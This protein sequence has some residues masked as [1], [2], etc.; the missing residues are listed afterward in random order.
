MGLYTF[1]TSRSGGLEDIGCS[2]Q[3]KIRCPSE[4]QAQIKGSLRKGIRYDTLTN[5][6]SRLTISHRLRTRSVT[7]MSGST[8]P[9]QG[10][11]Y[12]EP[13]SRRFMSF[14][15]TDATRGG[16][17]QQSQKINVLRRKTCHFRLS[18]KLILHIRSVLLARQATKK[19][20]AHTRKIDRIGKL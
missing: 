13:T 19:R 4:H 17:S 16:A 2:T 6:Y 15:R 3:D 1:C 18:P 9:R 20:L 11:S 14:A 10:L 8:S 7:M 12:P 5:Q